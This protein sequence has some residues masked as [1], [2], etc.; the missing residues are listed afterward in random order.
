MSQQ[1]IKNLDNQEKIKEFNETI[2]DIVASDSVGEAKE[3]LVVL[4]QVFSHNPEF[5]NVN[6]ALF[7]IY[8][9]YSV[10]VKYV[11]LHELEEKEIIE[12]MRENFN[13]ILN[14]PEYDLDLKIK[15]KIRDINDLDRRD[16]F[17][18]EIRQVLL[19]CNTPFGKSKL[20]INGQLHE[21]TVANWLKNYYVEAGMGKVDSVKL[22]EHLASNK[23]I[24]LLSPAE[25]TVLKNLLRFFDDMKVSSVKFPIFEESFVA[26][27][28][29]GEINIISGGKAEKIPPQTLRLYEKVNNLTKS[30]VVGRPGS[31]AKS[32]QNGNLTEL[33]ELAAK[34]P[35]GSIERKAVEEEMRKMER[36]RGEK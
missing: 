24:K 23:N 28:P 33:R 20:L 27:L 30:A 1:A 34:Y 22:S 32:V 16:D 25:Q 35:P 14:H 7:N 21:A 31:T 3:L 36:G 4:M 8:H 10:A 2:N 17:K 18:K 26:V 6:P 12:L 13:F 29:D 5:K 15:Y 19:E 9:N 11:V